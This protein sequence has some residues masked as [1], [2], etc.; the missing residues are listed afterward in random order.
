MF[1]LG[2]ALFWGGVALH[3]PPTIKPEL[4]CPHELAVELHAWAAAPPLPPPLCLLLSQIRPEAQATPVVAAPNIAVPLNIP[5]NNRVIDMGA[6]AA[7]TA[8]AT[9]KTTALNKFFI[10]NFQASAIA[11][12]SAAATTELAA[13]VHTH[14]DNLGLIL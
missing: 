14:V 9:K 8:A 11:G 2:Q 7:I 1:G 5:P 10:L 12:T 6:K 13:I 4:V 3:D